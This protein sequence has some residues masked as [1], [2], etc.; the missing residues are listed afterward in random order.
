MILESWGSDYETTGHS[1]L[2]EGHGELGVFTAR[3]VDQARPQVLLRFSFF[4]LS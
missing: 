2:W 4:S 3:H 1:V